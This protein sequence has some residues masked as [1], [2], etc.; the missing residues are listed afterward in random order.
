[1]GDEC[2]PRMWEKRNAYSIHVGKPEGKTLT[3]IREDYTRTRLIKKNG[4]AETGFIW[5]RIVTNGG[6]L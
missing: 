2:V 5:L 6:L 3:R 1:M 4:K